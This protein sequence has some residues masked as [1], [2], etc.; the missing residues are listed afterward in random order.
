LTIDQ[1]IEQLNVERNTPLAVWDADERPEAEKGARPRPPRPAKFKDIKEEYSFRLKEYA[2]KQ[3]NWSTHSS[4]YQNIWDWVRR[5][6]EPTMLAPH[7]ELLVS[8]GQLSLQNVIRALRDKFEPS[9]DNTRDQVR[10]DYRQI[11]ERGKSSS[12]DPKV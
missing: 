5:T 9:K 6:V 8:Q 12:I 10:E 7:L 3:A 11:L 2:I 4:R 1:I